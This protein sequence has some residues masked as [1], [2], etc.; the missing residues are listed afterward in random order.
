MESEMIITKEWIHAHKNGP[1]GWTAKQLKAL[2][3][4]WPPKPGW[5]DRLHHG[6][7]TEECARM[8]EEGKGQVSKSTLKRRKKVGAHK[9]A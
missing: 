3:L 9:T 4:K 7:I 1:G 8:F 6:N 2:G 5:I